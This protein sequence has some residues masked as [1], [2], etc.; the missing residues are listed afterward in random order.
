VNIPASARLSDLVVKVD[1]RLTSNAGTEGTIEARLMLG[2]SIVATTSFKAPPNASEKGG[3]TIGARNWMVPE[4][5]RGTKQT[6]KLEVR[7]TAGTTTVTLKA[8][9]KLDLDVEW[10]SR[11]WGN[12]WDLIFN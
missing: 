2:S 5:L 1:G 9:A 4:S 11:L 3:F 7:Q 6:L 8:G 10:S 12:L